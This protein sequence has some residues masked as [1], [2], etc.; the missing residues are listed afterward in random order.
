M[1]ILVLEVIIIFAFLN[2]SGQDIAYGKHKAIYM[3]IYQYYDLKARD[4]NTEHRSI[5]VTLFLTVSYATIHI[6]NAD[7]QRTFALDN[8]SDLKADLTEG[9]TVYS[10]YYGSSKKL[11]FYPY[12]D[13]KWWFTSVIYWPDKKRLG[14]YFKFEFSE[15][16]IY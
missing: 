5:D 9:T 16:L 6:S 7:G 12:K 2:A 13:N 10:I 15:K 4:Y 3:G 14:N 8:P 11:S 1:K